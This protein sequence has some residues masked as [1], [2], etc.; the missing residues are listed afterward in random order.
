M[1][2]RS[3]RINRISQRGRRSPVTLLVVLSVLTVGVIACSVGV[4]AQ[5]GS[6]ATNTTDLSESGPDN[7]T[8]LPIVRADDPVVPYPSNPSGVSK[9][10]ANVSGPTSLLSV[11]VTVASIQ[12]V[13]T[14]G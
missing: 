14:A 1:T 7:T 13:L 12:P 8:G 11:T 3:N 9:V 5:N 2:S 4:V 10:I 6:T